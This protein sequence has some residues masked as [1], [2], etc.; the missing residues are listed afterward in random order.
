MAV[1]IIGF[2]IDGLLR[3]RVTTNGEKGLDALGGLLAY[4]V[5]YFQVMLA[6]DMRD[7]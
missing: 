2:K 5:W 4:L 6:L 3:L 7:C 1:R